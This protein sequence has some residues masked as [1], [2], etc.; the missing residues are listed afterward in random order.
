MLGIIAVLSLGM[1]EKMAMFFLV[2]NK[3][4][5]Q[6]KIMINF[7]FVSIIFLITSFFLYDEFD[8]SFLKDY[9][10]YI[11]VLLENLVFFYAIRNY[12]KQ[13][14]FTQI[15]FGAFSSIYLMIGIGY[16]YRILM[17]LNTTISSPYNNI[18]EVVGFSLFFF[19]LTMLYFS[20]KIK[21]KDIKHPIDLLLYSILL[22]NTLFFA[23][24][25]FQTY[26]SFLLYIF[27]FITLV[28]QQFISLVRE[29]GFKRLKSQILL[30]DL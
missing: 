14:N 4:N 6:I 19:V 26:Q 23:I 13:K 11:T 3:E 16:F 8:F 29:K 5:Q 25:M 20:D 18:Q 2:K 30:S 15:A 1:A 28:V 12:N 17:N 21:N 27:I 24:L 10:F 9:K 7:L 22:V